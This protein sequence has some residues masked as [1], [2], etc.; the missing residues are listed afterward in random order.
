MSSRAWP[1]LCTGAHTSHSAVAHARGRRRR[2]HGRMGDMGGVVL[3]RD[4][5]GGRGQRLLGVADVALD[6]AGFLHGRFELRPVGL[7][8]VGL[9][10][11][12][13]PGDLER[14]AT[15]QGRP[16]VAGDDGHAAELPE[17]VGRRRAGK[18]HHLLHARHLQGRAGVEGGHL[19]AD[20]RRPGDDGE[21]HA[22]QHDILA[23]D[24]LARRD[25]DEVGDAHGALADVAEGARLLELDL[26]GLR[27][28]QSA[29][30]GGKRAV[31]E[32]APRRLVHD[33]VQ[34]C[35]HLAH[36][37][38][39]RG[40]GGRLQHQPHRGAAVPHRLYPM[41]HAARAVGVLVAV[42]P[43]I[44][45]RL[46]HAHARPVGLE[47]VGKH[48]GQRGARG[49]VAHLGAGR[50][51]A[52][53]AVAAD[54]DEHLGIADHAVGHGFGPGRIG[55]ERSSDRR[56]LHGQGEAAGGSH[57]LEQTAAADVG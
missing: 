20:H 2:L 22:G 19:A 6:L 23:V 13:V 28:R 4:H 46:H 52:D 42:G 40:G 34:L 27:D 35:L 30:R 7:G 16:G 21:L 47:L 11:P 8:V 24:R 50:H 26:V 55:R 51:D 29:C 15:L 53:R 44:A 5:L 45:R 3:A 43:L 1:G 48:H 14:L 54:G 57:A 36:V 37:D 9:V 33:L 38:L 18:R 12:V 31:S 10:G 32:L 56:E 39:P 17:L 41:A 25:V 49:T